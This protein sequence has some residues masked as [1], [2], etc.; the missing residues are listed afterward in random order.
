MFKHLL[1]GSTL[2]AILLKS[3]PIELIVLAQA[4]TIIGGPLIA[5]LLILLANNKQ[6]LGPYT[7]K[8]GSNLISGV[9]FLWILYLS[10]N[11]ILIFL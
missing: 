10:I 5:I 11:Q 1:I 6:V 7:N 8:V 2:L 9:A 4:S 3:N